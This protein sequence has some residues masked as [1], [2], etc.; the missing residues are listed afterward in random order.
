MSDEM[1]KLQ[2]NN[3]GAWRNLVEFDRKSLLGVEDAIATIGRLSVGGV[4]FRMVDPSGDVV[5]LWSREHGWYEPPWKT[6]KE[7]AG[8]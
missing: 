3:T 7:G 2:V 5:L 4:A 8:Q 6:L 1:Y